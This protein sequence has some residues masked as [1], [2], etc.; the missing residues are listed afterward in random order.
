MTGPL[1][2]GV[3]LRLVNPVRTGFF[4]FFS[5]INMR[6]QEVIMSRPP[7]LTGRTKS[8][9]KRERWYNSSKI[10]QPRKIVKQFRRHT[11]VM[12]KKDFSA[13]FRGCAFLFQSVDRRT[14][15]NRRRARLNNNV[16]A[17]R[18]NVK[19]LVILS[20]HESK[21]RLLHTRYC[22]Q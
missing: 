11:H 6:C 16:S 22:Y 1:L 14:V 5:K 20:V 19:I 7:K 21:R 2:A 12:Y 4:F 13:F 10:S 3:R 9:R 8:F 15:S 17:G 18:I